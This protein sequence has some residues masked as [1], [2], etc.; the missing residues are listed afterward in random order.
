[1][2]QYSKEN[3]EIDNTTGIGEED[4]VPAHIEVILACDHRQSK[5]QYHHLAHR[6]PPKHIAGFQHV[7]RMPQCSW[8]AGYGK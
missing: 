2:P 8:E 3:W 5:P 1:M 6:T 4:R 7:T